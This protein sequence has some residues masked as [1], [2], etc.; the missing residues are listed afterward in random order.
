MDQRPAWPRGVGTGRR[1]MLT[2]ALLLAVV[3]AAV[4]VPRV[5]SAASVGAQTCAPKACSGGGSTACASRLSRRL[6]AK[7]RNAVDLSAVARPAQSGSA[8]AHTPESRSAVVVAPFGYQ[9]YF[10]VSGFIPAVQALDREGYSV[11]LLENTALSDVPS[12]TIGRFIAAVRRAGVILFFGH[13]ASGL[14]PLET[15]RTEGEL[16]RLSGSWSI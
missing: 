5:V 6:R 13:A 2:A 12:I 9:P 11:K 16:V 3:C 4:A 8:V 14:L 15:Y 7:R 1:V 10:G